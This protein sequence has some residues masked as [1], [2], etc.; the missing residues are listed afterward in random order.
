VLESW[1]A[2][3]INIAVVGLFIS[4][5]VNIGGWFER[6][7]RLVRN[8]VF[9]LLM[10]AAAIASMLN[11]LPVQQGFILDLRMSVLCCAGLFGGPVAALIACALT[12]AARLAIGGGGAPYALGAIALSG[13]LGAAAW[14]VLRRPPG[15]RHVAL[16]AALSGAL[17]WGFLQVPAGPDLPALQGHIGSVAVF[18]AGTTFLIGLVLMQAERMVMERD[19][20]RATLLQAPD[21]VYVKNERHQ[22]IAASQGVA[23]FNGF[24]SPSEMLGLTDR[25]LTTPDR[26]AMLIEQEERILATGQSVQNLEETV[27]IQGIER[28][29]STTKTPL[30]SADGKVVG[31]AGVTREVTEHRKMEQEVREGRDLLDMVTAQMSDGLALF[32]ADGTLRYC[33]ELYRSMFP[34]TGEMRHPGANLRDILWRVVETGEQL[35]LPEDKAAWVDSIMSGLKQ[36]SEEQ[37][38][39]SNGTW[40]QLRSRPTPHGETVVVA[41][42][43][44]A[45]KSTE[46]ELLSMT[47]QLRVLA[48]TDG[49]TGLMNRRSFD[50]ALDARLDA[51][52]AN[53]QPLSLLMI[54]VDRFKAFNDIYGHLA[55]DACLKLVGQTVAH[56]LRGMDVVARFGGEEFVAILPDATDDQAYQVATRI[57]SA[58][59]EC[60]IAH[61]GSAT[62]LV[63]VSIGIAGYPADTRARS[64]SQLLARAD[65]ALYVAKDAGRDR[66]MGWRRRISPASVA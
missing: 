58:L 34:I 61:S 66:I 43:I 39:F 4:S 8:S 32:N 48:T 60:R 17:I 47:A 6:R 24:S 2:F 50:D 20:L 52:Q 64:A 29:F 41:T 42:D 1:G 30:H 31:I 27:L 59:R 23:E 7:P 46:A 13:G 37:V 35:N 55:G 49:L 3:G 45:M 63:T 36:D 54:D 5:W 28:T 11:A 12:A 14:A 38:R 10:G 65:E 25:E 21:F 9:G 18:T 16:I 44:T 56:A 53:G 62:G 26:A 40:V 19:L 51:T 15:V 22:I 33:N 57:Q